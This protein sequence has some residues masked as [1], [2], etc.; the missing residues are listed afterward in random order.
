MGVIKNI[1]K[2]L[3]RND[4]KAVA[5]EM[6]L[7]YNEKKEKGEKDPIDTTVDKIMAIIQENPNPEKI[8]EILAELYNEKKIPNRVFEKTATKISKIDEIP[9]KVITKVVE[10]NKDIS[11]EIINNIIEEGDIDLKERLKL[12]KNVEDKAIIEKLVEDEL[13]ILYE[14]TKDKKDSDIVERIEI[15]KEILKNKTTGEIDNLIQQV[16]ARKMAENFYSD[17]SK[18][19][20]IY[21]LSK[22]L[23]VEKMIECDLP[24]KVEKEYEK[25][26]EKEGEKERRFNK[27][28]FKIQILMQMAR[29]I[30]YK[31]E[32]TGVFVVPQS[33]NMKKIEKNQ[34]SEFIKAIEIFSGKELSEKEIEDIKDQIKGNVNSTQAKES[35]LIGAIKK[36]PDKNKNRIMDILIQ[37]LKNKETLKTLSMIE[38][39]GLMRQFNLLDEDKR[40]ETINTIREILNNRKYKVAK[41]SPIIKEKQVIK[42]NEDDEKDR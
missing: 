25:I 18:G 28:N 31:Y 36:L 33:K 19:T 14:N 12:I 13:N 7:L 35:L 30:A 9:D 15:L 4:S 41:K 32:E 40:I 3:K 42:F 34:E 26:Q 22:V 23:P 17:I 11:D 16:V 1:K 27:S 6:A 10:E 38:E 8:K 39:S 2:T 5:K 21:T 24:S 29:E 20:K 37:I